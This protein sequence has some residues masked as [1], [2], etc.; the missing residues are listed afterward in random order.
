MRT[1]HAEV[2]LI[3]ET[4]SKVV[5]EHRWQKEWSKGQAF[6]HSSIKKHAESG[7]A[8]LVHSKNIYMEN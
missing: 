6:L 5:T 3:Q 4:D 8:I 7:V 1:V 2:I